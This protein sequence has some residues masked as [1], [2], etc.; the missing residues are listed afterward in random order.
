M[1]NGTIFSGLCKVFLKITDRFIDDKGM[2]IV[3]I[4]AAFG[5]D[6]GKGFIDRHFGDSLYFDIYE[7]DENNANLLKRIDNS[8]DKDEGNEIHGDPVKAGG[9]MGLLLNEKVNVAVSK[10]F[11]PNIKRIQK[12]FVCVRVT[13]FD[14]A[15]SI[16]EIRK[17]VGNIFEEWEKGEDRKH[18]NLKKAL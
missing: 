2:V 5:T 10:N 6:D 17:N 9:I 15:G 1:L 16:K 8:T 11:G 3:K 14:I 12:K 13:G 4:T 7:I 18:L